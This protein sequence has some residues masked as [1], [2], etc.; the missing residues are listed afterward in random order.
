[1][2]IIFSK[3]ENFISFLV[4]SVQYLIFSSRNSTL[5][6]SH[7]VRVNFCRIHR[8]IAE[9]FD[10]LASPA[11][12]SSMYRHES[13]LT[14]RPQNK[15]GHFYKNHRDNGVFIIYRLY[16]VFNTF[17]EPGMLEM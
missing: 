14:A 12:K 17:Q 6:A 5:I 13:Q 3:C 4:E 16:N 15:Q 10:L 9:L 11:E 2:L 8:L 1:M 7:L